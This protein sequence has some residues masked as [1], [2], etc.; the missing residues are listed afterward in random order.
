MYGA[1]ELDQRITLQDRA[2]GQD[3]RGQANGA[4]ADVVSTWAKAEPLSTR[5]TFA[6]AAAQSQVSVRFVIR[7]RSSVTPDMRVMWRGRAYYIEGEP[8][9]VK[10]QQ[11]YLQLL[12]VAGGN[13]GR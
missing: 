6:A 5:E 1:G 12:C 8:I 4:W 9:D 3:D 13:D 10:G 2:S 7:Y 11:Q